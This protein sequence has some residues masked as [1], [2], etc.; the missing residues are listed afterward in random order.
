MFFER[1]YREDSRL[2]I[3]SRREKEPLPLLFRIFPNVHEIQK[4]GCANERTIKLRPRSSSSTNPQHR[5]FFPLFRCGIIDC[6]EWPSDHGD[7][8]RFQPQKITKSSDERPW[9]F[10]PNE[11]DSICS[12]S[13]EWKSVF[14]TFSLITMVVRL[15]FDYVVKKDRQLFVKKSNF[16]RWTLVSCLSNK[17]IRE[18][19]NFFEGSWR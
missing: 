6:A 12:K 15:R 5:A 1:Q 18:P 4:V 3:D 11:S 14:S 8:S 9:A 17:V 10:W 16:R 7:F 19:T 13:R 2:S